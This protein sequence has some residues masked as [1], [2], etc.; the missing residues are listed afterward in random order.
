MSARL[1][2]LVEGV[3]IG[4][5]G[6][7]EYL[8]YLAHR[9]NHRTGRCDPRVSTVLRDLKCSERHVRN[10]RSHWE[11][12]GWLEVTHRG[13][14]RSSQYT[15]KV[16]AIAAH[17]TAMQV[18]PE[19]GFCPSEPANLPLTMPPIC[20]PIWNQESNQ[21]GEPERGAREGARPPLTPSLDEIVV[22]GKEGSGIQQEPVEAV[23]PPDP[24][25][26]VVQLVIEAGHDPAEVPEE[27]AECVRGDRVPADHWQ[28][29]AADRACAVEFGHNCDLLARRFVNHYAATSRKFTLAQ[30]SGKFGN[31]C[32]PDPRFPRAAPKL[33]RIAVRD[34][35]LEETRAEV[36]AAISP[37]PAWEA[38]L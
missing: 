9:T 13:R 28:P 30:W 14:R 38:R 8:R 27:L 33:D 6:Q 37:S 21:E 16:E 26:E 5:K 29:T 12:L 31:W 19:T 1:V 24:E 23:E 25:P 36:W 4:T 11:G 15:L 3:Q 17:V 22:A 2:T 7:R 34:Q 18:V 20:P 35:W 32:L 10:C